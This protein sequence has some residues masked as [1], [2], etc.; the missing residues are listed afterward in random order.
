MRRQIA[1]VAVAALLLFAG[2]NG[3]TAT[4]T[5]ENPMTTTPADGEPIYETPLDASA[6]ADA[7]V[8]ALRDAG[9]YTMQSNATQSRAS[10]NTTIE[11]STLVRG[12]LSSGAVFTHSESRQGTV[13]A[14][15][16]GNGTAYRRLAMGDQIRYMQAGQRT[17]NATQYA[18]SSVQTFV[19]LFNFTYAGTQS[20]DGST[21]HVYE[22]SGVEGLN[23]SAQAFAGRLNE[24]M[25][26]NANA[27]L[28]VRDD[29]VVT[30][31]NYNLTVS[32]GGQTQTLTATQQYTKLGETTVSPPEWIDEARANTT[33]Q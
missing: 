31:A 27:T 12:D 1:A 26:E 8:E 10:Q 17:G 7:H 3:G 11:T 30:Q 29:G 21:V 4:T 19:T 23:T 22:A 15:A 25:V 2:C 33:S 28:H 16:F 24:S 18:R 20:A 5:P 13:E 32:V 9:T 6:V 14:F